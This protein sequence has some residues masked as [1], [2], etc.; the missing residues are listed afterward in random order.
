MTQTEW[1][2][3]VLTML[4]EVKQRWPWIK[5]EAGGSVGEI[6]LSTSA[7]SGNLGIRI[8]REKDD[9]WMYAEPKFGSGTSLMGDLSDVERGLFEYRGI[10]DALHFL[11]SESSG[12]RI[13]PDGKCPCDSC[14]ATGKTR[15][16]SRCEGKGVR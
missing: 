3:T 16:C 14:G 13:H 2:G 12:I 9:M 5:A 4:V 15:D 8:G 10:L 7:C 11:T 6:H 1:N